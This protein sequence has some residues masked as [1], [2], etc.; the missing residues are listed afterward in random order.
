MAL[1]FQRRAGTRLLSLETIKMRGGITDRGM[2]A[3]EQAAGAPPLRI[4]VERIR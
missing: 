4:N 3:G 2:G 1:G